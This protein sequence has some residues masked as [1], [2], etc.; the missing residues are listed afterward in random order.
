MN[1]KHIISNLV[2]VAGMLILGVVLAVLLNRIDKPTKSYPTV[3]NPTLPPQPG[4]IV[5]H[6]GQFP[7]RWKVVF[8]PQGEHIFTAWEHIKI[9][10]T[11]FQ[12]GVQ[13][14]DKLD[15]DVTIIGQCVVLQE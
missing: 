9:K 15:R 14:K 2:V 3:A 13:F 1:L 12:T 6:Y 4:P 5:L 8:Y 11:I 7:K 10:P